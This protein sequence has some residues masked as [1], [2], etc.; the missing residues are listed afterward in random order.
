MQS[1]ILYPALYIAGTY[2]R[3]SEHELRIKDIDLGL[4]VVVVLSDAI[5]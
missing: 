4:V 5:L 3:R 2:V 1:V